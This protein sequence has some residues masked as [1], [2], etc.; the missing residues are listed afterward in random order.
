MPPRA[1]LSTV[2]QVVPVEGGGTAGRPGRRRAVR[3]DD[4]SAWGV[5]GDVN[6]RLG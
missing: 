4:D 3:G 2:R 1:P 6:A 5:R